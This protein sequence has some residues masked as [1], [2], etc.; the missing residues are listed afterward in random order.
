MDI[1]N[2]V[3]NQSCF[4]I[5]F[6][7]LSACTF[8]QTFYKFD[9]K[10]TGKSFWTN[11]KT[12]QFLIKNDKALAHHWYFLN[13]SSYKLFY[14]KFWYSRHHKSTLGISCFQFWLK[15]YIFEISI[16]F[17]LSLILPCFSCH[18]SAGFI[19][20][21]KTQLQSSTLGKKNEILSTSSLIQPSYTIR[22]ANVL[23]L[24]RPEN[25]PKAEYFPTK[26]IISL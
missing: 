7:Q 10:L 16:S 18:L 5:T 23:K 12:T 17:S 9:W 22:A 8:V 26:R 2:I 14:E 3:F 6:F 11:P 13:L 25:F 20:I 21:F 1:Q 15:I 4:I 19:L 24:F